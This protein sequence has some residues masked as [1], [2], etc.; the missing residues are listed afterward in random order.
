MSNY[1]DLYD[2]TDF[3]R[4]TLGYDQVALAKLDPSHK[5]LQLHQ[6]STW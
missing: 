4:Y 6:I 5:H 2:M 3:S 1:V